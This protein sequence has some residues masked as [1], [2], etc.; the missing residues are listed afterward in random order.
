MSEA[1][2]IR[3]SINALGGQGGGVL[4]DW[5]VATAD[6]CGWLVQATSV[7]G[8]AQRTGATVYYLEFCPPDAAGR[9]PV[10]AL[11]PVPGDVDI[12]VAAEL[13]EAGR[14]IA[15]GFV[16]PDRTTLIASSHRIFAIAEKSAMGD[17]ITSPVRI[18]DACRMAARRLVLADYQALA[19]RDGSVISA[20]LFGALAGSGALPFPRAAFEDAIRAGGVGVN[21]SLRTFAAAFDRALAPV[22]REDA[23]PPPVVLTGLSHL[24]TILAQR[25]PEAAWPTATIGIE[26]L[27]DYQDAAYASLYL[28]RLSAVADA[29]RQLSPDP[30]W[31]LT[32]EA[33]RY[34][35]LWMS[36]EDVIRVA[37][38]KTRGSRLARVLVEARGQPEHIVDVTEYMHPRFEEL[39]D[40]LPWRVGERLLASDRS[41]RLIAPLLERD[42]TITTSRI[43]GFLLLHGIARLRRWRRGTLRYRLEQDRIIGWL[44]SALNAC[45]TDHQLA[46]EIIRCQRLVKGYGDTHARGLHNFATIM[47]SL[48]QLVERPGSA[49]LVQTLREAA[50]KDDEGRALTRAIADLGQAAVPRAA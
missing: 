11:M 29:E 14:A 49:A 35:A 15:R 43:S 46:V 4:A 22:E 30:D 3:L 7:P 27:A 38:L 24:R 39:C 50:L 47:R 48:P 44:T 26:R 10:Q 32:R 2:P 33:A 28:D 42:R 5:L 25:L 16:T 37:D 9:L 8:V 41:R 40:T 6:S 45:R 23:A 1:S 20:A 36:Y 19:E 21:S 18:L 13:M 17:G 12:V 31:T 34:L